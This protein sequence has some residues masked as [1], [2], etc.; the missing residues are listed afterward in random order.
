MILC[1]IK[2]YFVIVAENPGLLSNLAI[3]NNPDN[4]Y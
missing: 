1:T 3:K 4:T 2:Q